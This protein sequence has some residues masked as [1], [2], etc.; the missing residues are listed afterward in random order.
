M[1]EKKKVDR[2]G[3]LS[4]AISF[5]GSLIGLA[6]GIP[7]VA[8]IVSPTLQDKTD[9]WI[10][11]GSTNKVEPGT[12]TLMKVKIQEQTGRDTSEKDI[13]AYVLTD[14]GTDYIAMSNVC[15]HLGCRV[16]WVDDAGLFFCPCHNAAFTRDGGIEYGPQPRPL[17]RFEVRTEDDQLFVLA[18]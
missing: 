7:A 11:I 5:I 9:S 16:R 1:N 10:R 15:T 14:N 12:P 6:L 3:F 17:D 18:S 2:R 8:Y 4:I 13:A